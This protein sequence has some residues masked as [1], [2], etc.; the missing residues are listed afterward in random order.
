[1][2]PNS[3]FQ[4][5]NYWVDVV[6]SDTST[7]S[8]APSMSLAIAAAP[9][10]LVAAASPPPPGASSTVISSDA[11]VVEG[12]TQS[13]LSG[14]GAG[15]TALDRAMIRRRLALR[16]LLTVADP[17]AVRAVLNGTSGLGAR[18]GQR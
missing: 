4:S 2:F 7:G 5:T 16:R 13:V 12:V 18:N 11:D 15:S 10:T 8:A 14:G 3:S 6:F 9:T 1:V 17:G